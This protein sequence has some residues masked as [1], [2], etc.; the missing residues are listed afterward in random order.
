MT[1]T[2]PAAPL[3]VLLAAAFAAGQEPVPLVGAKDPA[4]GWKFDNGREFP[5]ATGGL[6]ADP[7]VT[8]NGRP[9]LKLVGDFTKGGGYVQAGR[10]IDKLDVRELVLW[11][12]N[13][14]ADRFTL[15][16]TDGSG[17]THQ[18][19]LKTEPGPDWQK[20]VLPVERFFA[21]RG[22]ADAVTT[23]AKYE[24]WG[25]AKDGRWH[26]PATGLYVLLTNGG[27]NA[28]RTLWLGDV[29]VIPPPTAVPGADV[30]TAVRLDEVADGRHDWKLSLGEVKGAKGS[31]AVE[32]DAGRSHLRLA[33]DFTAGGAYVAAIKDLADLDAKDVTA[34]RLRVRSANASTVTVQVVDATG[35]THQRKGLKLTAD[36][37]W[38][39]LVLKPAGLAGGEHWGGANDAK[40]HGPAARVV[41]SVTSESDP[42]KKPVVDLADVTADTVRSSFVQAPAFRAGFA[43]GSALP[44]GWKTAGDVSVD[45]KAR[46]N[47]GA[48]LLSRPLADV[49]KPCTAES[50]A[51]PV[52][53]GIW[54]LAAATRSDLTSPD[55]SYRGVVT[56]ECL[57]VAGKPVE[58]VTLAD[59]FGKRDW[60]KAAKTVELPK[61]V[62]TAKFR[63]AL[64]KAH[65]RFWVDDLSA[66][67]V[68]PAPRRDDRVS[69]LLFA[70]PAL[71][72]LLLPTD[73][74]TV[75]VT[76]EAKRPLRDDRRTLTYVVRD[77]WGAEQ[78]RPAAV[79]L[80][81]PE[82]DK[83]KLVYRATI[84]LSAAPL[85]VGRYYELHAEL[86]LDGEPF[87]N[88]TSFAI[89]PEAETKKYKPEEVPFT[90]RNWDNRIPEFIRLSDRL[91]VRVCGLWG[92]WS[93]KPPYKP[94]APGLDLCKQ[95]GMGWLTTTPAKFIEL[96]K[97]DYDEAALRQGVRNLIETYGKHRPLVINLGNE[98]HGTGEKVRANVEA[99][100]V[101]Y[102]EVKKVDPTITVVATSVEPNEEYFKLGYGK[103]CDAFDFHI[104]ERPED[105]RRTIGEYRALMKKYGVEKPIWSTE[106][107]LN[108]QGVPRHVVA[109]EVTKKFATF[110]A[111]GGANASWFGLLY[112]D[113]DGKQHGSSGDSHN[114]FDCRFNRYA[115]R[116]DAVAYYHAV[117]AIAVKKFVAEK[118][119]PGGVRA[120][121][122][123]DRD[124]K[125][126]Q[127]LWADKGRHDVAVLLPGVK[128][129]RVIRGDG[130]RR[131]LDADGK[132]VTLTVSE[133]PLLV[134]YDGGP[135]GLPD[136][137]GKPAA[138][139]AAVPVTVARTGPTAITVTLGGAGEVALLAP[140]FWDV[141]RA[142]DS[143]VFTVA[144]PA[145]SA[146]RQADLTVTITD[147]A[148]RRRGELYLRA[149]VAE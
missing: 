7:G 48:L 120:F 102:E 112:P 68:G 139:L 4:A 73:P 2:R 29:T 51:F 67:P 35:Q 62:A 115:P 92:G 43:T 129:V 8:H 121:L 59:V 125:S 132:D 18:L 79:A 65:G 46:D 91:G 142:A 34:F 133:E 31:F 109:A 105:V 143:L 66:A 23:V 138:V 147:A 116:L 21:R 44:S 136:A 110:F 144:P 149:L 119:Y 89:L 114:V 81:P 40:W 64:H 113:P 20:I 28:V 12:R 123:R 61:G 6:T 135:A 49:E 103:W 101:L 69:R 52:S 11:V 57:D 80:G 95:L 97:R 122:F 47:G 19:V 90:S 87:R 106:L 77:Y 88:H 146:V 141:K 137:F 93:A 63:V 39:D 108:S 54:Q 83:D 3:A 74:R 13:P 75:A 78:T 85:E 50:P 55:N 56:L 127:V 37:K 70:T 26:G 76:V 42:G 126:L 33:A 36:G 9:S 17:Q 53:P 41:I 131:Q 60:A 145:G 1:I 27:S 118:S 111:A 24:S 140:P 72:N 99:Y 82:K 25:G 94:E 130:T 104:Y 71:G 14:D 134:L 128:D 15:R 30:T 124:G 45:P 22:Q 58:S 96:G 148:G 5:G 100:R 16:L 38:H 107:G 86:P 32:T 10:A 84:D 117:N 98:P